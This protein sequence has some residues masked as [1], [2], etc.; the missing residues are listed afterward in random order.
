M[1]L[2]AM[3]EILERRH[4]L[5][6]AQFFFSLGHFENGLLELLHR[7]GGWEFST[8]HVFVHCVTGSCAASN[9]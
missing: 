3:R 1:S 2:F 8:R 7:L 5:L 6:T 9:F 4:L